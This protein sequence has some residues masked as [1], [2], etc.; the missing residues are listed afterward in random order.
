MAEPRLIRDYLADLNARL[1]EGIVE[2][3]RDCIEQTDRRHL[4]AGLDQ[5]AVERAAIAEFGP[6][7]A[8]AAAFTDAAP[9]RSAARTLLRL[10]PVVGECWAAA[11]INARA[12]TW[13]I[14]MITPSA[15]A[16]VLATVIALLITAAFAPHY[17]AARRA[18]SAALIGLVAI[19]VA[20]PG[21][22]ALP[23]LLNS[24]PLI[25]ATGLSLART[26]LAIRALRRI[27]LN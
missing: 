24:W 10:G 3:L 25:L 16:V 2:E 7:A 6:P 5:Y 11:L 20:L 4:D 22:L 23:G 19:D 12:W 8:I 14:P 21:T 13:T 18:A 27:R 1:P 17:R 15:V 9:G 26:G